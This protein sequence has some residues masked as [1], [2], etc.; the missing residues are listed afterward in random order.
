MEGRDLEQG[1]S[2]IK[3]IKN[4]FHEKGTELHQDLMHL[5]GL[6]CW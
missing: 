3:S 1:V 4:P 6:E 5:S 2:S